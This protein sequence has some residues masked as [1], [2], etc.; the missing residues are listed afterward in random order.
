MQTRNSKSRDA[1]TM[2]SNK[3]YIPNEAG[4]L[5]QGMS[6]IWKGTPSK[7]LMSIKSPSTLRALKKERFINEGSNEKNDSLIKGSVNQSTLVKKGS[8]DMDAVQNLPLI[9]PSDKKFL[10]STELEN[11]NRLKSLVKNKDK[12]IEILQTKVQELQKDGGNKNTLNRSYATMNY[13]FQ[14]SMNLGDIE[15]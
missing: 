14:N 11:L 5:D 3:L 8:G 2:S 7:M 12:E 15:K 6:N 1:T 10:I 4:L 13:E 9:S